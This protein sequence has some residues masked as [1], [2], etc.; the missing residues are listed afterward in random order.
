MVAATILLTGLMLLAN[1]LMIKGA[2]GEWPSITLASEL[3]DATDRVYADWMVV[4]AAL[5]FLANDVQLWLVLVFGAAVIYWLGDFTDE[6]LLRLF[7]RRPPAAPARPALD[8][9][10]APLADHGSREG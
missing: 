10:G 3:G 4:N 1:Q 5:R 7:S 6:Q 8:P 2:S 9:E